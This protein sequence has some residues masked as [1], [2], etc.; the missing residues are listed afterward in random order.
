M[1]DEQALREACEDIADDVINNHIDSD[2]CWDRKDGAVA[3]LMAFAKAQRAAG[4]REVLSL[5]MM[6]KDI[7]HTARNIA[8][9]CEARARELEGT[10]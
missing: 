1:M 3:K 7:D 10:K 6:T 2:G 9:W 4:V 8:N 5:T